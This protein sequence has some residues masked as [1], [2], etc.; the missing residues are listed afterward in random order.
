MPLRQP[1]VRGDLEYFDREV[2]GEEVVVVRDPVRGTYFKYNPLQAAMLRR[3]DGVRSLDQMVAELS[4]EF[5]VEIPRQAAERFVQN[6]RERML[7]DIASL[8]VPDERAQKAVFAALKR[9]GF[10][11][12]DVGAEAKAD[13]PARVVSAEA[14]MFMG[15]IR[16]LQAGYPKR[17]LDYFLAVLELNPKNKR[18]SH[19]VDVIQTAYVKA[20]GGASTDFP[21]FAKFDPTKIL[22]FLDRTIGRVAFHWVG[23]LLMFLLLVVGAYCYSITELPEHDPE[24]FDFLIV[25]LVLLLHLFLHELGHGL[26]C[27]HYGGRVPEIGFTRFYFVV[28]FP[29]CDTSSSY[30]F[31]H[32]THQVWVQLAGSVASLVF[33]CLSLMLLSVLQ[34]DVFFYEGW[35]VNL[36]ITL[37]SLFANLVPLIKFDG[38]YALCDI[39]GTPNLRERSF[40]LLK[41][42]LGARLLGIPGTEEPL[43]RRKRLFFFAFAISAF[44]FTIF[45]L[46]QI[47]FRIAAPVVESFQGAGLVISV[48][49]FGYLLRRTFLWP[50]RNF[51]RLIRREWRRLLSI[52][53]AAVLLVLLT[54]LI[55]PW[56]LQWEVLVDSDFVLVPKERREVRIETP[57]IVVQILA[58]EGDV[59]RRGQPLAILENRELLLA[60]RVAEARLESLDARLEGL[61]A[62]TRVE[63]IQLAKTQVLT[64]LATQQANAREARVA[65]ELVRKGAGNASVANA[66]AGS[67]AASQSLASAARWRLA[68][69][70]A[71]SRE[72]VIAAAEAERDRLSAEVERAKAELA[73][74]TIRSPIDGVVATKHL[75]DRSHTR[76]ERGETYIEIHDVT[77]FTAEIKLP[78]TAPIGE[79]AIGDHIAMRAHAAP[80]EMIECKIDRIRDIVDP[81]SR[82]GL[83]VVTTPFAI[84]GGRTGMVGHARLYG[85]ERSLAYSKLY[86]P[87]ERLVKVTLWALM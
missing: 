32:R 9:E 5:E 61:R 57:G 64:A 35:Q 79:L 80:G 65:A 73:L 20:L 37:F 23:L 78:P 48:L 77:S 40:K 69:L 27:Y 34:T 7:L 87:L 33:F 41:T 82:G 63:E 58:R 4:D 36:Y 24:A 14:V 10:Q 16:Q 25:Y 12:R 2:E 6:A 55:V 52:R 22:A 72:E 66:T 83:I 76:L 45:W 15:G 54:L 21:T 71:G 67:A 29:Y 74:L 8:N 49:F 81:N 46:Y 28:P 60:S 11:F 30:L 86:L 31:K 68:S 70:E 56:T 3:L 44:L 1:K 39:L 50:L 62:G 53:R 84:E 43:E 19:L 17:A 42:W 47:V 18:A 75:D 38:Y 85:R 13:L 26:A 59:V 51:A